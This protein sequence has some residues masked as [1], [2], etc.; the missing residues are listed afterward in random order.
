MPTHPKWIIRN[1][2]IN[3]WV[4]GD[5]DCAPILLWKIAQF[6]R[7]IGRVAYITSG[8]RSFDEQKRL[9]ARWRS[10]TGNL[11]AKPG[12]SRHESGLAADVWYG[13]KPI[14]SFTNPK[15]LK[16]KYA[17]NLAVPSEEW[18]VEYAPQKR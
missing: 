2:I 15:F 13:A 14:G 17:L 6:S 4:T 1:K 7:D 5:K 16:A 8:R 9:Y 3:K 12:T 11:A 18:H 10:G